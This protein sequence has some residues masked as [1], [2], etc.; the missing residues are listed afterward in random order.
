MSIASPVGRPRRK[1]IRP[2]E[3]VDVIC[4][5]CG[6]GFQLSRRTFRDRL[7]SDKGF[8]CSLCRA[9]CVAPN[10]NAPAAVERIRCCSRRD[11]AW[12]IRRF[13]GRA[14]EDLVVGVFGPAAATPE[15]TARRAAIVA[16][17]APQPEKRAA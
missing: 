8:V 2:P 9:L 15:R 17:A 14:L 13:P 11:H 5:E 1:R 16:S 7:A 3:R 4:D 12:W 10:Q 6:S